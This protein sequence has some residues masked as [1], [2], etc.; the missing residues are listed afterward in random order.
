MQM[1]KNIHILS[2]PK[3]RIGFEASLKGMNRLFIPDSR[4]AYHLLQI[5]AF[6]QSS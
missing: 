2:Q 1:E 4:V 6:F 5:I 3:T